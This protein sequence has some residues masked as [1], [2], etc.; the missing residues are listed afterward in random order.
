MGLFIRMMLYAI[1]S[2]LAGEGIVLFDH[3]TG[4]VT[5]QIDDLILFGG[6]VFGFVSTFVAGRRAKAKGGLT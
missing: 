4:T 5:F 1:F 3:Q 2:N 6:G